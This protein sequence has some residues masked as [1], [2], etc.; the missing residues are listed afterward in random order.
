MPPSAS[1]IRSLLKVIAGSA[2]DVGRAGKSIRAYHGSPYDFDAINFDKLQNGMFGPG[3]H[4]AA[5]LPFVEQNYRR[6]GKVYEVEIDADPG[7]FLWDNV[8]PET[9]RSLGGQ[10]ED[11][12][13]RLMDE[14][15]VYGQLDSKIPFTSRLREPKP[16]LLLSHIVNRE[17]VRRIED[18]QA[19]NSLPEDSSL[20]L[21]ALEGLR[22][23]ARQAA[24]EA[25]LRSGVVGMRGEWPYG[26]AGGPYTQ[27]PI[28]SV[29]D[30]ERIRIL[31]KFGLLAPIA[32]GSAMGADTNR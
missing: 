8:T 31:R 19:A 14:A 13:R 5:D 10:Q 22:A 26:P 29:F 30:P 20:R 11:M 17:S 28:Y 23:Q 1:N 24:R 6:R 25:A 18:A 12:L 2:D 27:A 32:A 15:A 3:F 21:Q 9:A 4:T 16:Q 7:S